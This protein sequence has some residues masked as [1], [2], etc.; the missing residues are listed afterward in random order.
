MPENSKGRI[1]G[2]NGNLL[3]VEF[4]TSVIQNEVA[5]AILGDMRLKSEVIRVRGNRADLQVFESTDQI[6]IG[7]VVEFTGGL[8]SATLGPGLLKQ[9]YDGLQ[10]PLNKLAEKSGFFL[11]RGVY[12]DALDY[13]TQWEFTPTAAPGDKLRAGDR[14]GWVPEGIFQHWIMVP[15]AFRG[16]WEVVSV[17]EK[18]T[19]K[20]K[21]TMAVLRNTRGEERIVTMVQEWPV[22]I[23][24][25]CYKE[26][27]LP[28]EPLITQQRIIDTFFPVAQGGT[29]CTPGPFGAGKT[30]LQH[31]ISQF[32]EADVVIVAACG[33][34]A[35]EVV[36]ILREFPELKDPRTGKT[37]IDRSIII[38]NTSSMPVAAREASVYTAGWAMVLGWYRYL[39]HSCG[40]DSSC[41]MVR[42]NGGRSLVLEQTAQ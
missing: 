29:F 15:F 30:V 21:D 41:L 1:V 42:R 28:V 6:R 20:L 19:Y 12:L 31:A 25:S 32:A 9:V 3:T 4:D 2:V 40:M 7:D 38:C 24:I 16:V 14:I 39:S 23:P 8:L 37:L 27:L 34:R 26:K 13:E 35:G 33:E 10:N 36:E 5:F 11:E 22:K 17:T 18:G